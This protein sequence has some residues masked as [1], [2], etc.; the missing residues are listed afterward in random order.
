[1]KRVAKAWVPF[2]LEYPN[3]DVIYTLILRWYFSGEVFSWPVKVF[4]HILNFS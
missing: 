1:M 4:F 2:E 3:M